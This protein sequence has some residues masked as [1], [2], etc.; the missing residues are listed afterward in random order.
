[1]T[2]A[3]VGWAA[4]LARFLAAPGDVYDLVIARGRVV[5]PASRFDAVAWVGISRGLVQ[6]ISLEA[7]AGRDTIDAT[8]LVVAP[9]FIDYQS[10]GA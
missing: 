9:G 6:S 7:L 2:G 1:M 4:A 8:G 5:D 10:R 3:T